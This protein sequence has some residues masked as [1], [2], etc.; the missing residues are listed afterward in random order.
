MADTIRK[1]DYFKIETPNKAGEGARI[2]GAF[3]GAGVNMLAFTGFPKGRRAQ[4]DFMPED[5]AAF[6][7]AAKQIG[8]AVGA[9]K[10][11]FLVQGEDRVGAVAEVL[12]QLATVKVNVT[13]IDAI[14]TGGGRWG[15]IL[16]VKSPDV[17]K[18]ARALKA[19]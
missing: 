19:K 16:W 17:A 15:A 8:L 7:K 4:M 3:Q 9:K 13:A 6:K 14:S 10:T 5:V 1:V 12:T 18:A 11:G 2:L